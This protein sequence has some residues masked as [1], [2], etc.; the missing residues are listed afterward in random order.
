MFVGIIHITIGLNS[1]VNIFIRVV[2]SLLVGEFKCIEDDFNSSMCGLT[3]Q[4]Y[5]YFKRSLYYFDFFL[6]MH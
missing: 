6:E 4:L 5:S 1:I 3:K 2:F